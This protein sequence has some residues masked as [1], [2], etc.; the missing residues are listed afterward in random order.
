MPRSHP[1]TLSHHA[2]RLTSEG[3]YGIGSC[4]TLIDYIRS[5]TRFCTSH[6]LTSS[7][8]ISKQFPIAWALAVHLLFCKGSVCFGFCL[9]KCQNRINETRK[10]H[11]TSRDCMVPHLFSMCVYMYLHIYIYY[12]EGCNVSSLVPNTHQASKH[13]ETCVIPCVLGHAAKPRASVGK[14][15][16]WIAGGLWWGKT[17]GGALGSCL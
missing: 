6:C 15:V 8:Y 12:E 10:S 17:L 5:S 13:F 2:R 1:P 14:K 11:A 9:S 7:S 3:F 4:W 16:A